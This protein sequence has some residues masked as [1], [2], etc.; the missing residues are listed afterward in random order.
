[1]NAGAA[2]QWRIGVDIGGTFTDL[3][4][5]D[6]RGDVRV[7][8]VPTVPA[9]PAQGAFDAVS[10]AAAGLGCSVPELLSHTVLFV[11]GST[12]AT[13]TVLERSGARVGLLVTDG[14]RD[15]LEI[16]RGLRENPWDHRLP[17][18]PVL[19]PRYLRRPVAGR[20]DR[21]GQESLALSGADIEHAAAEFTRENVDAVVIALFN[22]YVNPAHEEQAAATLAR[23][24]QGSW[25]SCSARIAPVMGEYERTS[26]AVLNAYITPR[27][28]T[29]LQNLNRR[30][31]ELGLRRPMLLIQSNG[32]AIA[33]DQVAE[34]PVTLLLSGPA[35]G[36]GA[37]DYYS[38]AI[39]SSDLI[40]MEIGGTSCDV[41]LMSN[42]TIAYTDAISI[43]GYDVV[44]RSVDVHS[45]GAGGGTIASV[46][47]GMLSIGPQGA[48]AVPG[49]ACYGR[50][51]TRATVTDAQVVL[52]RLRASAAAG[53][54]LHIDESLALEAI[55]R[56]IAA[57]LEL[58][59]E[60][61]AAGVV[62]LMEQKLLHAVQRLSV[63]RGHDPRQFTLVAAGGAGP[64][65]GAEVGR[66]LGCRRL[67]VPRLAGAFCALGM[68]HADVRHDYVRMQ[69]GNLDGID[70]ERVGQLFAALETD[71]R[72]TLEQEGFSDSDMELSRLVDL[73]Y[74]SQQWDITVPL[75]AG[76]WNPA[77]IRADFEAEHLRQYGHVQPEGTIE[78]TRQ[79]ITGTGRLPALH[80]GAPEASSAAPNPVQRRRVWLNPES[81]WVE[82]PVYEGWNLRPGQSLEGPA[83][84]DE[85][86][87]TVLIDRGDRLRVDAA[88]NFDIELMHRAARAG[89][90]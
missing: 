35:A 26:T 23:H 89:R 19:V 38:R 1:M 12:I 32:G 5:S 56:E 43:G 68:L 73:R 72:H 46:A 9:D 84:I 61:A 85:H 36:V 41:L 75:A 2:Q 37:L 21:D 50:G 7:F 49:P 6:A 44:T 40:S 51:G 13:N 4:L 71:A 45:I 59:C 83:I 67:Y 74:V 52:G 15:A 25:V 90:V 10:A 47:E 31:V 17:Y 22:S 60:A 65:H 81:G 48:G 82:T 42:G 28:V 24:W 78:I 54:V 76:V 63:E 87:T 27:T 66:L 80:T 33:V 29:Y 53:K 8:K 69:L 62:R 30:L 64:L 77:H 55:R 86:T 58:T 88:G 16:R 20:I 3:V 34:R 18:P 79:R 39:E 11:H 70:P 14:F 57:P